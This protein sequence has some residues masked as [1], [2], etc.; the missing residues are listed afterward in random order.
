MKVRTAAIVRDNLRTGAGLRQERVDLLD[1]ALVIPCLAA[2]DDGIQP[3]A[4]PARSGQVG[5]HHS[6]PGE[7]ILVGHRLKVGD[8][9]PLVS[10][11]AT[12]VD[13]LNAASDCLNLV[14]IKVTLTAVTPAN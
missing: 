10:G 9:A 6:A 14:S 4:V 1:R 11:S 2:S 8:V 12:R 5:G 13:Q 3:G 7:G